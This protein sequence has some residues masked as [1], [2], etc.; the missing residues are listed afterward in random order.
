MTTNLT[1]IDGT[2]PR[3]R[4]PH[5]GT[6]ECG[7]YL[8]TATIEGETAHYW[9]YADGVYRQIA[10]GAWL[11]DSVWSYWHLSPAAAALFGTPAAAIAECRR[12][13]PD[14]IPNSW[15]LPMT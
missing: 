2:V 3:S 12:L 9:G 8:G 10:T 7:V 15:R 13:A 5:K 1:P 14:K 4:H 11:A 6:P